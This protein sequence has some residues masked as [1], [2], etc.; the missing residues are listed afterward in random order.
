MTPE[1]LYRT[2]LV[3]GLLIATSISSNT[4]KAETIPYQPTT[5]YGA[6]VANC[7]VSG[8]GPTY[9]QVSGY[10][11]PSL[12]A[13]AGCALCGGAA[14]NNISSCVG[15]QSSANVNTSSTIQN[16]P[17]GYEDVGNNSCYRPDC[18]Q[19]QEY[20]EENQ[21]A[22][23][24]VDCNDPARDLGGSPYGGAG[25]LP[26]S[27]CV[28]GCEYPINHGVSGCKNGS[29]YFEGSVGAPSG[30][31]SEPS[32]VEEKDDD[33]RTPEE[34]CIS[35]ASG[36]VTVNG[37]V[38]CVGAGTAGGGDITVRDDPLGTGTPND[39]GFTDSGAV[40]TDGDGEPDTTKED[41]CKDNPYSRQ[42]TGYFSGNCDGGFLCEGDAALCAIA[43][44]Q[45]ENTCRMAM[46]DA[47]STLGQTIIEGNDTSL[48]PLDNPE[49]I[50]LG[51]LDTSS[52]MP[53]AGLTDQHF[54]IA[55]HNFV[56]PLASLNQ[57]L[58]FAG[59]IVLAFAFIAAARIVFM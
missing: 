43:R 45:H 58:Q 20:N 59:M 11:T 16:C 19:G 47:V 53:K 57:G 5:T 28:L 6:L 39:T 14:W 3:I 48:N 33:N 12:A 44:K 56:L 50:D 30:Q 42:C 54:N 1:S 7:Y 24:E 38:T 32:E 18:P 15:P 21:C 8:S 31:C 46:H 51:S 13:N 23:P 49:N 35:D 52:F 26:S 34:K 10:E 17:A 40:D 2:L 22:A 9:Y 4:V 29:C 41:Y 55:G 37:V 27:I 36:Y 25:S